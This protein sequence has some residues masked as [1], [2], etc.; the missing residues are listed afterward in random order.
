VAVVVFAEVPAKVTWVV[1]EQ[2]P[3]WIVEAVE[4]TVKGRVPEAPALE[5]P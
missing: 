2:H 3:L 4:V 5:F 1:S